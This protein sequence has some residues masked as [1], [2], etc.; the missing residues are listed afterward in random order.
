[1]ARYRGEPRVF[2]LPSVRLT[3]KKKLNFLI[4]LRN[5]KGGSILSSCSFTKTMGTLQ[6]NKFNKIN[7]LILIYYLSPLQNIQ[8]S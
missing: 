4:R 7:V 8:T 2:R 6:E 1:M 5:T 3:I